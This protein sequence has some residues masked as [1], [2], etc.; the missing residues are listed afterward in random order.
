M[1]DHLV[2]LSRK[3]RERV[4]AGFYDSDQS[5]RRTRLSLVR[6]IKNSKKTPV[7]TEIKYA[8]P[9]SG[10]IR[11][12]ES[13][14]KIAKAMLTGGACALSV[15][16][17]PESFR[18]GLNILSEVAEQVDV[19]L[20]MKDIILSPVQLR[21]GARA[22]ADAVVLISELFS[23]GLAEIGVKEIRAQA[24]SLGLE[25]LVEANGSLE[26]E[27]IRNLKPDLY[28]INNRNLETFQVDLNTTERILAKTQPLDGPIVSESGME[29]AADIRRLKAAGVQAFLVGTSI[30][31]SPNVENKVREL[32]NA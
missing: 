31:K 18:G 13:P 26:F 12:F 14:L 5:L 17:E 9:S 23:R 22:G 3:A 20:I 32:V 8:S 30:M 2:E 24:R 25:V 21:A 28:G 27:K 11:E 7:I 6:T 15:M 1:S 10:K 4:R 29:S 19:P 16:T